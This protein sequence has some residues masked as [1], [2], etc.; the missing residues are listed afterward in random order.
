MPKRLVRSDTLVRIAGEKPLEQIKLFFSDTLG[1][2]R[3][4]SDRKVRNPKVI[5]LF[6][7][8]ISLF[9]YVIAD[10]R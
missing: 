6:C 5:L 1:E 10:I 3:H 8:M 7:R 4:C 2:F 9:M